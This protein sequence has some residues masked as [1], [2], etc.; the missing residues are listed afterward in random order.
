[1]INDTGSS[2]FILFEDELVTLSVDGQGL[3]PGRNGVGSI[4]TANGS[5][6]RDLCTVEMKLIDVNGHA[7]TG[8]FIEKACVMPRD[9]PTSREPQTNTENRLSG[10]EMRDYMYFATPPLNQNLYI[11]SHKSDLYNILPPRR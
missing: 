10:Q 3:Y 8:W 5:I 9:P 11:S 7:I 2:L 4:I 6:R 1:M